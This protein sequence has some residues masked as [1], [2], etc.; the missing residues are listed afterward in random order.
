MAGWF[1]KG[2]V[3]TG[4][5]MGGPGEGLKVFI[6]ETHQVVHAFGFGKPLLE[7]FDQTCFLQ[8]AMK[9]EFLVHS[10]FNVVM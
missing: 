5:F 9:G 10:G 8:P 2:T 6:L 1:G 3:I 7:L 4:S